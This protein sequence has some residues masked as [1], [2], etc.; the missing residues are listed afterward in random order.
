[1]KKPELIA[2]VAEKTGLLKSQVDAALTATVD[3]ITQALIKKE[4]VL[5]MGIGTFD[6]R[7]R[8]ARE[9]RNPGTGEKILIP[10]AVV[11]VFKAA[12]TL[13]TALNEPQ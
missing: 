10:E 6:V 9:G 12:S 13:K 7:Q 1:M 8:S 4:K 3:T 2:I 5:L 11:P